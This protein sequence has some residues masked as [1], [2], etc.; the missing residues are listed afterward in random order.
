M[1]WNV[2][3]LFRIRKFVSRVATFR[4]LG[5]TFKLLQKSPVSRDRKKLNIN[6]VELSAIFF[7]KDFLTTIT[8]SSLIPLIC[9]FFSWMNPFFD[10]YF[11]SLK[12]S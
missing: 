9:V 2:L 1:L 10:K 6:S 12:A 4:L 3:I 7:F 8:P 11:A 5:L